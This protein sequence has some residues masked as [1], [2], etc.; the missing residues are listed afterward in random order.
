MR[1]VKRTAPIPEGVD[2]YEVVYTPNI[3]TVGWFYWDGKTLVYIQNGFARNSLRGA[4]KMWSARWFMR[5]DSEEFVQR[6]AL[7]DGW[8]W[9]VTQ[10]QTATQPN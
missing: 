9:A 6:L 8:R 5:L 7:G 3:E 4:L 2:F 1:E 10:L